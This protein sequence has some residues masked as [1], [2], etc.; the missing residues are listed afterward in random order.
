MSI[1]I[2]TMISFSIGLAIGFLFLKNETGITKSQRL[3]AASIF[4]IILAVASFI[5]MML[6]RMFQLNSMLELV[7][8]IVVLIAMALTQRAFLSAFLTKAKA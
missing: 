2:F 3:T 8:T 5:L 1:I 7:S 4:G 6:D